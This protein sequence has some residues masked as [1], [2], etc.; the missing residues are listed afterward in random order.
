MVHRPLPRRAFTLVELLVVI[1]IIAVLIGILLPAISAA[2]RQA[3]ATACAATLRS[4]GQSLTGYVS[5]Y[6]AYPFSLYYG[7]AVSSPSNEQGDGSADEA[8]KGVYVWWSVLRGYMRGRGAP[9]DNSIL[10][11]D[12]GGPVMTRFMEAFNCASAQN[13]SAGCDFIANSAIMPSH[14]NEQIPFVSAAQAH[15][16]N[17]QRV[18]SASATGVYPDNIL[19]FDGSELA[20][21]DPQFSRQYVTSYDLDGGQMSDP[22]KP[23]YRYREPAARYTQ[24]ALANHL[25]INPGPNKESRGEVGNRGQVRWRHGKNTSANFL[26]V[27]GSVRLMEIT[28]GSGAT[29]RGEVLRKLFR[30]K[31][32]GGYAT[33]NE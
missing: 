24:A 29:I 20:N 4:L 5:E 16:V 17:G 12:V 26:F 27:D 10:V 1:G 6:R 28:R 22:K 8:D 13:R 7:A 9:M 15:S 2:R 30:P 23:A 14:A 31:V 21:V 19:L 18:K 3:N 32:P 11:K 25:P 33:N